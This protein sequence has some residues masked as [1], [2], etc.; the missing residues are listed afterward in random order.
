MLTV[1][2]EREH[3]MR[4]VEKLAVVTRNHIA[5]ECDKFKHSL[6]LLGLK[7]ASLRNK[8]LQLGTLA[9]TYA[10]EH[11]R[12]DTFFSADIEDICYYLIVA[13]HSDIVC[14]AYLSIIHNQ[15]LM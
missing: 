7:L 13:I 2:L 4:M 14:I 12:R 8:H 15:S 1:L 6:K 11:S 9:T 3:S 10:R 5:I